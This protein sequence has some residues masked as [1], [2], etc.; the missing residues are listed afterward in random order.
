MVD[1]LSYSMVRHGTISQ[2]QGWYASNNNDT[3]AF[4]SFPGTLTAD[5]CALSPAS[6]RNSVGFLDPHFDASFRRL[7]ALSTDR[8]VF[9]YRMMYTIGK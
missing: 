4:D 9:I 8:C 1:K 7:L 3:S 6:W 5:G 2:G